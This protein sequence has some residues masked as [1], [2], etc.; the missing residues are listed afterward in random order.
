MKWF[1][2]S[3][4]SPI[5]LI[6]AALLLIPII[7]CGTAQETQTDPQQPAA[8]PQQPA[9]AQQQA[10]AQPAATQPPAAQAAQSAPSGSGQ[11][12]VPQAAQAAPTAVPQAAPSDATAQAVEP[13]GTLN[14]GLKEMGPFFLHPS[15]LGNP[16]IFVQGTAPIGEGLLQ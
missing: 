12:T 10:P 3:R 6:I 11:T 16:Q 4:Y 14:T 15:N 9:A 1:R 5:T 7:A 2:I 8:A 13:M